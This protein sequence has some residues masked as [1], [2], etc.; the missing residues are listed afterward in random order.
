[1][2]QTAHL[3]SDMGQMGMGLAQGY[4]LIVLTPSA[5]YFRGLE[6]P[7]KQKKRLKFRKNFKYF[8]LS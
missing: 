4:G 3:R 2:G 5:P 6:A 8:G 1:M 7:E